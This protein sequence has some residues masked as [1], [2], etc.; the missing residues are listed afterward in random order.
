[1]LKSTDDMDIKAVVSLLLFDT[2]LGAWNCL[3]SKF[4]LQISPLPEALAFH[5]DTFVERAQVSQYCPP[6]FYF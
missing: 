4:F 2:H 5:I 1:M 3:L 6:Y